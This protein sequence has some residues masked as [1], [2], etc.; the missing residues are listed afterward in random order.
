MVYF[1]LQP[2]AFP[3]YAASLGKLIINGLKALASSQLE[4][5][6][7]K[8]IYAIFDEFSAFAGEQ[9]INLINQGRNVGIHAVLSTQSL[10]D[11]VH[12]GDEA[13]LGQV[14][15][16]YNNYIIQRQNYHQDAEQLAHS[17]IC[18]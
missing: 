9:I 15:S 1:C 17:S 7:K 12:N 4:K 6:E 2:L 8:A 5:S 14:L 10:A 3:A 13:L 16:N 18:P 11:I